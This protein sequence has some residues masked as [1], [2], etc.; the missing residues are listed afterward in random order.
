MAVEETRKDGSGARPERRGERVGRWL[1]GFLHRRRWWV[2]AG[3]LLATALAALRVPDLV[4]HIRVNRGA[5]QDPEV[6]AR[7]RFDE[8]VGKFGT[9]FL[10]T[11]VL[12]GE[13]RAALRATA[14]AIAAK[15]KA[16]PPADLRPGDDVC[17]DPRFAKRQVRDV[18]H[19]VDLKQFEQKGIYYL[20]LPDL[21]KIGEGLA[22]VDR[23]GQSA[24]PPLTSLQD[25][26]DG[27]VD[28]FSQ[29]QAAA[30]TDEVKDAESVTQLTGALG[31]LERWLDQPYPEERLGESAA[32]QLTEEDRRGVDDLG[33]LSQ[34]EHPIRMLLFVRP[35]SDSEDESDNRCFITAVRTV[36]HGE[37]A[38][39]AR[40]TGHP[41]RAL[42]TG[43][44]AVVT[45]EMSMIGRDA[46]RVTLF[47]GAAIFLLL[48][49]YYRSLRTPILLLVPLLFAIF[50]T[51]GL[52]SI[53]IGRLTLISA[54]FGG[55][56]LGLG[57]DYAVQ[58]FQ[59]YNDERLAGKSEVD[60]AAAML[61]QT[62]GAILTAAVMTTLAF[63]GV[64]LTEFLGFAELG[65][66]V[67]M[68]IWMI[69]L[70][71]MLLLPVLLFLFHKPRRYGMQMQKGLQ[72]LARGRLA[73]VLILSL[74]VV[75]VG[76]GGFSLKDAR[77]DWDAN[78]LL[79]RNA[80]SVIGIRALSQTDYSADT[81][82]VTGS[83]AAELRERVRRLE[84]LA[85]GA[86][87]AEA[88]DECAAQRP[89]VARV[90]WSGRYERLLP[91][92]SPEKVEAVTGLRRH[93][94]FLEKTRREAAAA[95]A[96]PPAVEPGKVAEALE[97]IADEAGNIAFDFKE[98]RPDSPLTGAIVGLADAAERLA[99]R[100]RGADAAAMG[101]SL[102]AFQAWLLGQLDDGLGLVLAGLDL[103]PLQVRALPDDIGVRFRSRDGKAHAAYVY[104]T[105]NIG[106]RK[107]L[108]CLV[109]DIERIDPG[110]TGFPMTHYANA[111]E[112][113]N[114]F[115]SAT[116]Y[117]FL[118][119]LLS[120]IIYLR[121]VWH[122]LV[123]LVPLLVGTMLVVGVQWL[124][125]W[126]FNF[127]NVMALPV[128][129]CTGVDYGVYLVHRYREDPAGVE[130]F[131]S[132]SA[133]VMLCALTTIIGFGFL[134]ISDHVGMW[135][136]GFSIS[137]GI[138]ACYVAAQLAVPALL[139]A[140]TG[141]TVPPPA[142][143][144]GGAGEGK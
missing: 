18:F 44:P 103:D 50:W 62:G 46:T 86:G 16:A 135:S 59:R 56:L 133:G 106:D 1:A 98:S 83:T 60:A 127:V 82:I 36:A 91:E 57:V 76:F 23:A 102:Q 129:V 136:L 49:L 101:Q 69:F 120:L 45:D 137:L 108:P 119:V 19:K 124:L 78:N 43:N 72:G 104:P 52:V 41:V 55:V 113:E 17:G 20:G 144:A 93:R 126:P 51:L 142:P 139:F 105:G 3:A 132:T 75:V 118:A 24:L 70:G 25:A 131:A 74:T 61:G 80:E 128:L 42:V 14:D 9:P 34:G 47:A 63:L 87:T 65:Q 11:V 114:S 77:L 10:A 110:A 115:R 21:Q 15:L 54:Y 66:I 6:P 73:R 88:D 97:T 85:H 29:G 90:E 121:N 2:I 33:Y 109:A 12:E 38:R 13:D 32:P 7:K 28:G 111:T 26:L 35:V 27:I 68:A 112:I 117:S 40:E 67:A 37:S 140:R 53:T 130:G 122:V 89:V 134:M 8:V 94:A 116:I 31:R 22:A 143:S 95:V 123:T 5:L 79:Q 138:F 4:T 48:L 125:G 71:T 81:V 84:A 92:M 58:L 100:I 96:N 64:G 39:V 99:G 30:G 141:K 107:F